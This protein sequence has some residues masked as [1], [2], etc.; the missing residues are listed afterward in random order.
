M[1]CYRI[2][3]A[4]ISTTIWQMKK[5]LYILYFLYYTL[6]KTFKRKKPHGDTQKQKK[7]WYLT[8]TFFRWVE[9]KH[10]ALDRALDRIN[11]GEKKQH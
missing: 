3:V 1:L 8:D 4:F 10:H 7:K 11:G 2:L 5:T 9:M 6:D